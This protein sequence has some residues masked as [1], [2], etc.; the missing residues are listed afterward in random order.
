VTQTPPVQVSPVAQAVHAA[1][2]AALTPQAAVDSLASGTHPGRAAATLA[3]ARAAA[4]GSG[5]DAVRRVAGS[6]GARLATRAALATLAGRLAAQR[7]AGRSGAASLTVAGAAPRDARPGL[8]RLGAAR[9]RRAGGPVQAARRRLLGDVDAVAVLAAPVAVTRA[10]GVG[11]LRLT[12]AVQAL[13]VERA[14]VTR[15]ALHAARIAGVAAHALP[16][17]V[18]AARASVGATSGGGG[19]R[20]KE[21]KGDPER[22]NQGGGSHAVGRTRRPGQE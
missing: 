12:D 13:L 19:T 9:A 11:D 1:P 2:S 7:D 20:L 14:R 6:A 17:R 4:G 10:A 8:A 16:R 18:A 15:E 21:G 5:A 22:T 3:V